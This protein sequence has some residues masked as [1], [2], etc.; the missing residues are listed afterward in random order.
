MSVNEGNFTVNESIAET[1]T[2]DLTNVSIHAA[3]TEEMVKEEN[4]FEEFGSNNDENEGIIPI[5]T[6]SS[7][8]VCLST[9]TTQ[10]LNLLAFNS[11]FGPLD[12]DTMDRL[13]FSSSDSMH[14]SNDSG[15]T[16]SCANTS[17]INVS[18]EANQMGSTSIKS[19][20]VSISEMEVA[21]TPS[22]ENSTKS[23]ATDLGR[24]ET[25]PSNELE[26]TNIVLDQSPDNI[27]T[28]EREEKIE[29][30]KQTETVN[31]NIDEI[32]TSIECNE[33]VAT[34]ATPAKI[35]LANECASFGTETSAVRC[36][37]RDLT[38]SLVQNTSSKI[39]TKSP[40]LE[41]KNEIAA[42][43]EDMV[44]ENSEST[45]TDLEIKIDQC[46]NSELESTQNNDGILAFSTPAKI[47]VQS[48][49]SCGSVTRSTRRKQ[50]FSNVKITTPKRTPRKFHVNWP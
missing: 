19:E 11:E 1:Q 42:I 12:E 47:I 30:V 31:E 5:A 9:D 45:S 16:G 32:F 48:D 40:S 36:T 34:F 28:V 33:D 44:P 49:E 3:K 43:V 13:E 18:S 15:V 2:S 24:V 27:S 29:N 17:S 26:I 21:R 8:S 14:D 25:V 23:P 50:P 10:E 20:D 35:Q 39:E 4:S 38:V 41:V 37:P 22:K 46:E 7:I 6:S